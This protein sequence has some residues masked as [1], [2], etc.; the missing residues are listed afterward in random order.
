MVLPHM[1]LHMPSY[2]TILLT[3][4]SHTTALELAPLV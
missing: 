2:E 4:P 3:L 1:R